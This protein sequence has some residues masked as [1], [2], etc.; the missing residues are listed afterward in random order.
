LGLG[1]GTWAS[2]THPALL[3]GPC[4][5]LILGMSMMVMG[6]GPGQHGPI[7]RIILRAPK[8]GEA[9]KLYVAAQSSVIGAVLTQ[10]E[11]GKEFMVGHL[12]E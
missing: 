7:Y 2:M 6:H 5:A 11:G 9:C 10:E 4:R 8:V 1:L 12:H 3:S